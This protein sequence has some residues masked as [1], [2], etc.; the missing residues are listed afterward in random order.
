MKP[1]WIAVLLLVECKRSKPPAPS[2][3]AEI[4]IMTTSV[5]GDR[6]DKDLATLVG[7]GTRN[8][9]SAKIAGARDFI[10]KSFEDAGLVVVTDSFEAAMCAPPVTRE[11]V[12]GIAKGAH[13]ER[14]ILVGAHYD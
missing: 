7:F 6:I 4:S 10:K 13:P 9:C 3:D 14:L 8:T 2:S 11:S 5:S 12:I 1:V